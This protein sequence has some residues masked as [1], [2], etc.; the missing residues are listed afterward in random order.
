MAPPRFVKTSWTT[1]KRREEGKDTKDWLPANAD[2]VVDHDHEIP[3]EE[4]DHESGAT[5]PLLPP[6][7]GIEF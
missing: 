7:R 3:C 4:K 5:T 2:P 1:Q 6:D